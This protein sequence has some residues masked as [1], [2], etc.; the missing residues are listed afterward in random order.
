MAVEEIWLGTRAPVLPAA[1]PTKPGFTGAGPCDVVLLEP[2]DGV[3]EVVRQLRD[4]T[5]MPLR[6]VKDAIDRRPWTLKKAVPLAEARALLG[7]LEALG[8]VV[9]LR[10]AGQP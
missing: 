3:I 9:E 7:R 4:L 10:P 6:D 1:A 8:A 2:G 5:G